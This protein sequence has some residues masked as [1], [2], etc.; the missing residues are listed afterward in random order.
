MAAPARSLFPATPLRVVTCVRGRLSSASSNPG[1]ELDLTDKGL[2]VRSR[3]FSMLVDDGV[4]KV[5]AGG[6]AAAEPWAGG[7]RQSARLLLRVSVSLTR[8]A[9]RL[10]CPVRRRSTWRRAARSTCRALRTCSR[11]CE[12][13]CVQVPCSCV[14]GGG[15][16][17]C[18]TKVSFVD[19]PRRGWVGSGWG[20]LA[21]APGASA[22]R[23]SCRRRT[24]PI[25]R[26]QLSS[27]YNRDTRSAAC[28]HS[29]TRAAA[30]L[31]RS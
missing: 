11:R 20:W 8:R 10:A 9:V 25:L 2:G 31:T 26:P 12:G 7:P 15:R 5:R 30:G 16:P 18:L 23:N 4:V 19:G 17:G 22:T 13:C 21:R 24:P 29:A 14:V 3:R 1:V 6:G 27:T 28:C